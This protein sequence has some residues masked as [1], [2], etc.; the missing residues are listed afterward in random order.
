[1]STA[2]ENL[3]QEGEQTKPNWSVLRAFTGPPTA[4]WPAY[5]A[6]SGQLSGATRAALLRKPD[7][8][9]TEWRKVG[10]WTPG[11]RSLP[12]QGAFPPEWMELAEEGL[13]TGRSV[14]ALGRSTKP[15]VPHGVAVRLQLPEGEVPCIG[16]YLL[17]DCTPAQAEE[18]LRRLELVSDVPLSYA[19]TR[20]ATRERDDLNK[21]STILDALAEFNAEQHFLS[22]TLALCNTIATRFTCD[23]VS[24][25]W[26]LHGYVRLQAISRTERFDRKMAAVSSLEGAME[27]ALDQDEEIILPAPEGSTTVNR[28]HEKFSA[29]QKVACLV[30]LP[31]RVDDKPEA[32]LTCERQQGPFTPV[33][34]QQLRLLVD[35]VSRRLH[36]LKKN[37]RWFGARLAQEAREQ[38]AKL[39]GPEH[40]WAKVIAL[41]VAVIMILVVCVRVP[42]RVEA[43]FGLRSEEVAFLATPF[44]GFI[45]EALV[46]PGDVV[47]N[48]QPLIRL[49]VDDL[50]LEQAASLAEITR[51]Q[52]EA[53]RARAA[54][55]LEEMRVAL[56]QAEQA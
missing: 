7:K 20:N 14:R 50:L 17:P 32:V 15:E 1:M 11:N 40:T 33:E 36:E 9:Q 54:N 27:E 22:A 48:Q 44:K 51:Y 42:Y 53:E 10:E 25:G 35:Q 4:F 13:K 2:G 37:D 29:E 47:T 26:V 19:S 5:L 43:K 3:N 8:E 39:A 31:L 49:S 41:T 55:A 24:L 46:R 21:F 38:L 16:T 34:L 28:D 23:R 52:R 45:Q 56:S 12:P 6:A 30:S 18:T